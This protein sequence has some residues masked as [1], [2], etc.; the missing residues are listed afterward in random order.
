MDVTTEINNK[1]QIMGGSGS[2]APAYLASNKSLLFAR[3]ANSINTAPSQRVTAIPLQLNFSDAVGL[4]GSEN[5]FVK[6]ELDIQSSVNL[7]A[8]VETPENTYYPVW[9][10]E[11]TE[12]VNNYETAVF[13]YL[14]D[15]VTENTYLPVR[16][17]GELSEYDRPIVSV[18]LSNIKT[19]NRFVDAWLEPVLYGKD[20]K[21][22]E[23][24]LLYTD[25]KSYFYVGFHARNT[26]RLPY[27]V[28][29]NIGVEYLEYRNMTEAQRKLLR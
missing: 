10:F 21:R 29:V 18:Q 24:D 2:S 11:E 16:L 22:A 7:F 1:I 20:K 13:D 9:T 15:L 5:T 27:N 3:G 12:L 6:V 8:N 25:I 17:S 23:Q 28:N 19:G 26:R 14:K 4:F